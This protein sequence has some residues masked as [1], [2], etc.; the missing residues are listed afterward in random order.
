MRNLPRLLTVVSGLGEDSDI[1]PLGFTNESVDPPLSPIQPFVAA[2]MTHKYL[3]N[4]ITPGE[5]DNG[6]D[7]VRVLHHV[8]FRAESSSRFQIL[9]NLFAGLSVEFLV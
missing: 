5:V 3:S 2:R 7:R 4:S 6:A 8:N 9:L 1:H